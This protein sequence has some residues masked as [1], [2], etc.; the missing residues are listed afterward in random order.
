MTNS[1][2]GH[3]TIGEWTQKNKHVLRELYSEFLEEA[4]FNGCESE[5]PSYIEF[6]EALFQETTHAEE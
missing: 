1:T 6:Q 2:Q 3:L 5:A 4:G